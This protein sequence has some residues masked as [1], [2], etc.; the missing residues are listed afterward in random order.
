M[1]VRSKDSKDPN[2]SRKSKDRI[3]FSQRRRH[4]HRHCHGHGHRRGGG[5]HHGHHRGHGHH[6]GHEEI[7]EKK[8]FFI[9]LLWPV[10]G[11]KMIQIV[12]L[13]R[14]GRHGRRL[15][16]RGRQENAVGVSQKRKV[17]GC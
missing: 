2:C 12:L 17:P 1:A 16:H 4:G 11:T 3:Y 5:H 8:N 10:N 6:H 13:L 15:G 14:C 9:I 7:S